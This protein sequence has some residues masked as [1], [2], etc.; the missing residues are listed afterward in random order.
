MRKPAGQRPW[1]CR[2]GCDAVRIEQAFPGAFTTCLDR[3]A[4]SLATAGNAPPTL[5]VGALIASIKADP[6]QAAV[7]VFGVASTR[8]GR[9]E[10]AFLPNPRYRAPLVDVDLLEQERAR[11]AEQ[12]QASRERFLPATPMVHRPP[13]ALNDLAAWLQASATASLRMRG[14]R[15]CR[16]REDRLARA[17]RGVVR[18][19]SRS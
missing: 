2:G 14:D 3:A 10:P 11:H 12:R 19:R 7:A 13:S 9:R 15:Q 1:H 16:L 17:D 8:D 5:R 6:A 18:P 4:R